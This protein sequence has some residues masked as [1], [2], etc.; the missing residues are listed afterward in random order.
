MC[1]CRGKGLIV[2]LGKRN[3]LCRFGIVRYT[4]SWIDKDRYDQKGQ[5]P[6]TF[7]IDKRIP[8][9]ALSFAPLH[10][11]YGPTP[12][13]IG[14]SGFAARLLSKRPPTLVVCDMFPYS[15]IRFPHARFVVPHDKLP[16]ILGRG[17]VVPLKHI[18]EHHRVEP[19]ELT[20]VLTSAL[21]GRPREAFCSGSNPTPARTQDYCYFLQDALQQG[22]VDWATTIDESIPE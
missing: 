19:Y 11:D 7:G 1:K 10:W 15:C 2:D 21:R 9:V 17:G 4:W 6:C 18:W 22:V 14:P 16:T 3:K 12:R 5:L 13:N 20:D 8:V